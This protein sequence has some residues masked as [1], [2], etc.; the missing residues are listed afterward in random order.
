[1]SETE[2][3]QDVLKAAREHAIKGAQFLDEKRPDWAKEINRK[4]LN[5]TSPYNCVLGQLYGFYHYG[6]NALCIRTSSDLGFITPDKA[7]GVHF[8]ALNQA[9]L[10]LIK[11]RLAVLVPV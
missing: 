9:W 8:T 7:Q 3:P 4:R 11:E 1:M 2:I 5:M 6:L 10:E